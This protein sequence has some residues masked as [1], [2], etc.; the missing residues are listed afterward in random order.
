MKSSARLLAHRVDAV[1]RARAVESG[2]RC[3]C[4]VEEH[5]SSRGA[6]PTH[7]TSCFAAGGRLG[8]ERASSP[9][10]VCGDL[11]GIE[12]KDPAFGLDAVWIE[13][14]RRDHAQTLGYTVVDL[15][16]VVATHLSQV[17]QDHASELLGRR[18]G[19]A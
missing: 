15:S 17:L 18:S 7:F 8:R 13:P 11:D 10:Q 5:V 19:G 6:F 16:T 12:T 4:F 14:N 2:R 3:F 1:Q 9:G